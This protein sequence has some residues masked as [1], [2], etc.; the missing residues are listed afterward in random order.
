MNMNRSVGYL[1]TSTLITCGCVLAAQNGG[2]P[3]GGGDGTALSAAE[4]EGLQF[5]R[6]EEKLARDVYEYLYDLYGTPIFNN[7]SQ[8]EQRHTDAVLGLLVKYGLEDPVGDNDRGVFT[9]TELQDLYDTLVGMGSQSL[10]AAL[11]VGVLIEET[12]IVDILDTLEQV[13][14]S[15]IQRVYENLLNGSYNHWDAFTSQLEALNPSTPTNLKSMNKS[16]DRTRTN[17]AGTVVDNQDTS[18][19]TCNRQMHQRR[20]MKGKCKQRG[21]K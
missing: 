5:M 21:R 15:D 6:E 12:D 16:A 19:G 8:S 2:G 17:S 9:N 7:I 3:Q 13:T 4:I 18:A 11:N 20:H 1:F 10:E 14:H